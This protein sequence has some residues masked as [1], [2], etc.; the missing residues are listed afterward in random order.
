M[1]RKASGGEWLDEAKAL[2]A[3]R[4]ISKSCRMPARNRRLTALPASA[5]LFKDSLDFLFLDARCVA[6]HAPF[7]SDL[8]IENQW[9]APSELEA[10][11]PLVRGVHGFLESA[12]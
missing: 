9:I 3:I 12:D 10:E 8:A 5:I 1:A 4:G 6:H 11:F 7:G 2:G